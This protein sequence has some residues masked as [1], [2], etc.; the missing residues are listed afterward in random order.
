MDKTLFID[1]SLAKGLTKRLLN[2]IERLDHVAIESNPDRHNFNSINDFNRYVNF[3]RSCY[4]DLRLFDYIG[5]SA[6]KPYL[7]SHVVQVYK[8]ISHADER[9]EW[10]EDGLIGYGLIFNANPYIK[11]IQ[12]AGYRVRQHLITRLFQRSQIKYCAKGLINCL[13]IIPALKYIPL[14]WSFW[15]E[16]L[17]KEGIGRDKWWGEFNGAFRPV[18]PSDNGLFFCRFIDKFLD[19]NT[20]VDSSR[21]RPEQLVL[22]NEL[23]KISVDILSSPLP[24]S[25][26]YHEI[27]DNYGFVLDDVQ[28]VKELIC[29]RLIKN[30]AFSHFKNETLQ[31]AEGSN[32]TNLIDM[33]NLKYKLEDLLNEGIF[34]LKDSGSI[35][36]VILKRGLRKTQAY[37]NDFLFKCRNGI[38]LK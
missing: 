17:I 4:G 30:K 24:F 34:F 29:H 31:P 11:N 15:S 33:E 3:T 5:G 27:M 23:K 22:L 12:P 26:Q 14:W 35:E 8:G 28:L 21:L 6:K 36:K 19:I 13:S 1:E 32:N 16:I 20:Y 37:F 25:L 7:A 10:D 2:E 38:E 9:G 18:I